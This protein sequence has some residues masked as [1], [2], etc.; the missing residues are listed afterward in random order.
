MKSIISILLTSFLFLPIGALA[1]WQEMEMDIKDRIST[2]HQFKDYTGETLVKAAS[3]PSFKAYFQATGSDEKKVLKHKIDF[4]SMNTQA[5]FKVDEMC[6]IDN[7][8]QEISRIVFNKVAPDKELSS[9]EAS[10]SFF[11]PAFKKNQGDFHISSPYVSADSLRWV[12][13]FATPIVLDDGSK[14]G[15]YHYEM[16]LYIFQGMLNK[17]LSQNSKKFF[18][19]VNEEGYIVSDS[20]EKYALEYNVADTEMETPYSDYFPMLEDKISGFSG[21]LLDSNISGEYSIG[22]QNYNYLVKPLGYNNWK[23]ILFYPKD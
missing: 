19:V 20:R 11:D 8:G 10:A 18:L 15:I 17:N 2:F 16:S 6:L 22:E 13:C 12:I 14:P 1:N 4:L 3:N 7:K 5:K 21:K 23:G 9:Q